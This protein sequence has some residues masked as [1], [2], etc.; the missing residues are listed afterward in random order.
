MRQRGSEKQARSRGLHIAPP[1]KAHGAF[2]G[3]PPIRPHGPSRALRTP[4]LLDRSRQAA[5]RQFGMA[6]ACVDGSTHT[7]GNAHTP[8]SLP[9]LTQLFTLLLALKAEGNDR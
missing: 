1:P 7:V 5:Q 2:P 8:S 6:I 9:S 4:R 3:L